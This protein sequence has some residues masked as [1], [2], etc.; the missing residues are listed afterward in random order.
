MTPHPPTTDREFFDASRRFLDVCKAHC[1]CEDHWHFLW[2]ALKA[3]GLRRGVHQQQ[4]VFQ[5]LMQRWLPEGGQVL[6][7]GAADAG[8]LQVLD[9]ARQGTPVHFTLMDRCAAPLEDARAWARSRNLPLETREADVSRTEL[10]GPW[11]LILVHNTLVLMDAEARARTLSAL[12]RALAPHGVILCNMR[13]AESGQ[14]DLARLIEDEVASIAR[15]VRG[16]FAAEPAL[17]DAL[18]P[19]IRPNV[20]A[21]TRSLSERADRVGFLRELQAAGLAVLESHPER[22]AMRAM[23][24]EF[25]ADLHIR[26]ELLVLRRANRAHAS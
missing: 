2:A 10:G 21:Q 11:D 13:Y 20:T 25:N 9:V 12:H 19:M 8:S 4:A 18:L 1:R 7:L 26:A 23:V 17:V 5:D 15:T 14:I 24:S 22:N 6:I 16:T 3:G